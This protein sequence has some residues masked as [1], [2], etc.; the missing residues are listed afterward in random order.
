[1]TR[2]PDFATI[3]VSFTGLENVVPSVVRL[4]KPGGR[5]V[6]LIK[7]QFQAKRNEVRKGGVV[8][9]PLL[10]ATV[11]GRVVSWGTQ[12]ALRFGG[13]TTSPLRGPAGNKEFF[14]L[15]KAP[16]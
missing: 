9:D 5:I 6:A 1:M 2:L 4:L 3:D 7:P 11:I 10:H 15:W 8:S 14:I 12:H 16:E 13:L